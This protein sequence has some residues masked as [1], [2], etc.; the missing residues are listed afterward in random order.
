MARLKLGYRDFGM[1]AIKRFLKAQLRN[2]GA[3]VSGAADP[4]KLRRFFK[5][6]RPR[7][8]GLPLIRLGGQGDGGYLVPDDLQEIGACFSPG[9]SLVADFELELASRGV[10][11]FLA[12]A[13]VEAPPVSHP[14]FRFEKKFL[15]SQTQGDF[16]TLQDW[17]DAMRPDARDMILQMDIEGAEYDVLYESSD[18]LLNRF[19]IIIIEFHSLDELCNAF[20]FEFLRLTFEKLARHFVVAH[21]HPNNSQRPVRC[22]E[23]VIPPVI[24]VTFLR[25]DRVTQTAPRRDF[26]HALDRA[27]VNRRG[28]LVLP[29]CWYAD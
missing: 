15:G 13:S 22:G 21:I 8:T 27:N 1:R 24:E 7:E 3:I 17:V 10:S 25:R 16:V 14:M 2:Q 5:T 26:P 9:V 18:A 6:I 29:S 28:D 19:R 20:A 23:F 12:D 11:C 4:E